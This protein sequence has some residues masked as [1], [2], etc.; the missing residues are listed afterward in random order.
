PAA[1]TEELEGERPVA[2]VNLLGERL[3][4]FRDDGG[5]YG[6]VGRHCPHR[7]ADLYFGRVEDCG[8]RCL[9]HGWLFDVEGRCL[10]QPAEPPGSRMHERLRHRAYPCVERNGIVWAW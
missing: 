6:L 3:V 1:L 8:L 5:R 4:L 9:F 2:A 7:G 10:E